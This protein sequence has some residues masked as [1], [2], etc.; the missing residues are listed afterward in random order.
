MCGTSSVP[1]APDANMRAAWMGVPDCNKTQGKQDQHRRG[2]GVYAKTTSRSN[3][4]G[5]LNF[6]RRPGIWGVSPALLSLGGGWGLAGLA[7]TRTCVG[8]LLLLRMQLV[9]ERAT[10]PRWL[11]RS[12]FSVDLE[13]RYHF[14]CNESLELT[15]PQ[16]TA[17]KT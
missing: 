2:S 14:M 5:W 10:E 9:G 1:R 7:A 3:L 8:V 17:V 6:N 4:A 11:S 13:G 16:H 15:A 12:S